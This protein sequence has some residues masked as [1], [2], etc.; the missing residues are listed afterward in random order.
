MKSLKRVERRGRGVLVG[1]LDGRSPLF[2][3]GVLKSQNTET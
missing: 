3:G 1:L 2:C